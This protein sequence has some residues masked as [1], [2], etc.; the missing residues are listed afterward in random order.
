MTTKNERALARKNRRFHVMLNKKDEMTSFLSSETDSDF[1]V[2]G[3][4]P[5]NSFEQRLYKES[6]LWNDNSRDFS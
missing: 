5:H 4:R 2:Q 6:V 1:D 3:F